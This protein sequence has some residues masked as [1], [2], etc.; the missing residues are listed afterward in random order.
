MNRILSKKIETKHASFGGENFALYHNGQISAT[1]SQPISVQGI[2]NCWTFITP[3]TSVTNRVGNE[4]MPRGFSMRMYLENMGDRPNIHYRLILG[5][6]PKLK[7]NNT[8]TTWDDL[9]TLLDAGSAGNL[10]RHTAT[11]QGFKI[12]Y[13]RVFRSELGVTNTGTV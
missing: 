6:A 5:A 11:D 3:G 1:N 13:D 9:G 8:P 7:P 10:V 12:Y 2:F 4:I